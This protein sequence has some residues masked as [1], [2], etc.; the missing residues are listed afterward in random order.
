MTASSR[1]LS[2]HELSSPYQSLRDSGVSGRGGQERKCPVW[3]PLAAAALLVLGVL[4]ALAVIERLKYEDRINEALDPRPAP[5]CCEQTGP[6]QQSSVVL[7]ES[8]PLAVDYGTN[9]SSGADLYGVWKDL[10]S[11]ASDRVEVASFYWCLTGEDI[12]VNSSSDSRG[13]EILEELKALPS[14]NVSVRVVTSIPTLAP[15]STDLRTLRDHGV[16]IRRVNFGRLTK[17]ILHSKF[18]IVDGKHVYI[19]SANMDWRALTQ[20]KELGVVIYN[21]SALA[22]DLRKIF[23][24]YWVMGHSNAS[25]PHPWPSDYNTNI[26]QEHPLIIDLNGVKSRAYITA[27]P[28]LFCPDSRTRDLDAILSL[29]TGAQRFIHVAVMEFYPASKFFHH[30]GYWPVIEDALKRSAVD[31]GVCVRLLVS[32]G[33]ESDPAVW[34]FI[35]SLDALHSP[36]DNISVTVKVFVI[37]AGNRSHIPYSRINHNKYM[38]TDE[39]AYVG[40]SNW[41]ADYFDTTAGVGLVLSQDALGG[42]LHQQL[43]AVFDRDWSSRYSHRLAD[44]QR[45]HDCS[46]PASAP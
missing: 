13:R 24:S 9:V 26:N 23:R 39:V 44:L 41:S 10:L 7:V 35:R 43:R 27:S 32:C 5:G 2:A 33:R 36:A 22:A 21:S 3:A 30:H 29:I 34:P 38:V 46:F 11:L 15:N 8:F 40:T 37:P 42:S 28:P 6:V 19:G 31:R 18:W 20:V 14:R 17:G 16:Q 45:V 4:L 1:L 25:V 12:G